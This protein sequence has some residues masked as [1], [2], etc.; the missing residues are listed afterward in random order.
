MQKEFKGLDEGIVSQRL[1]CTGTSACTVAQAV[2]AQV[3]NYKPRSAP[4]QPG[5]RTARIET[6]CMRLIANAY[7]A[8]RH[9]AVVL[10]LSA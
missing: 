4:G 10:R 3:N 7:K 2:S 9:L 8:L 5:T 6:L 1:C